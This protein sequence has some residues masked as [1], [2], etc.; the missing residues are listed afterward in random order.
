MSLMSLG[1]GMR[2]N[3]G[4][5]KSMMAVFFRSHLAIAIVETQLAI[6]RC[7][8]SDVH[9]VHAPSFCNKGILKRDSGGPGNHISGRHAT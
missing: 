2:A 8:V 4:P 7:V 5:S 1:K 9:I 3:M 6:Q